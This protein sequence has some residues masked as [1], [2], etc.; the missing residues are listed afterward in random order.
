MVKNVEEYKM[1]VVGGE[2]EMPS[3][4]QSFAWEGDDTKEGN[5]VGW[6]KE[7]I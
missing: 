7:D 3:P 5:R 4:P 2:E 6:K 1:V